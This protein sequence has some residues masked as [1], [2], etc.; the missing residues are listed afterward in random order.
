MSCHTQQWSLRVSC[1]ES[2]IFFLP[3]GFV[4]VYSGKLQKM[5]TTEFRGDYT[6]SIEGQGKKKNCGSC[7]PGGE[8]P[9]P[10][11]SPVQSSEGP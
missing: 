9:F 6:G 10:T 1:L 7:A 2:G 5:W 3:L 4:Q 11:E 8:K